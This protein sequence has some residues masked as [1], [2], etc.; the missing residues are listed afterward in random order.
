MRLKISYIFVQIPLTIL[1][2]KNVSSQKLPLF[3]C[4]VDQILISE[5]V[6]HIYS[7]V[8]YQIHLATVGLGWTPFVFR[9]ASNYQWHRFNKVKERFLREFGPYGWDDITQL[10]HDEYLPFH[11]IP[12]DAIRVH[13]THCMSSVTWC[14][15]LLPSGGGCTAK[16]FHAC[17]VCT[18]AC[19]CARKISPTQL[20][21]D[22]KSVV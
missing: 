6:M 16:V 5:H 19:K 21:A 22:R 8:T 10:V 1:T 17:S 13:W 3:L 14:I 18:K 7:P 2:L 12:L 20:L 4:D 9:T 15:I 11:C